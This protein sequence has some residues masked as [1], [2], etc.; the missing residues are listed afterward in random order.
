MP[1]QY[2]DAMMFDDPSYATNFGPVL[3]AYM[4][5]KCPNTYNGASQ[6][7]D[8]FQKTCVTLPHSAFNSTNLSMS[9][10]ACG[11]KAPHGGPFLQPINGQ[12][13]TT[14]ECPVASSLA[15]ACVNGQNIPVRQV[16]FSSPGALVNNVYDGNGSDWWRFV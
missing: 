2:L 1:Q 15:Q 7:Y 3:A 5:P 4:P 10:G 13:Y 9:S 14:N 6:V 16:P 8:V 12:C 11:V